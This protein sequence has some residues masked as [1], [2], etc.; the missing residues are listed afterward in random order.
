MDGVKWMAARLVRLVA[1]LVMATVAIATG[2]VS[3]SHI[4]AL[5]LALHGSV[6]AGHLMPIGVDG[7]IVMGSVLLLTATGTTARWGWLGIG[8]GLA[9][10]LFANWE[11][12]IGGGYLAASWATV[13]ALSFAVA[14]F[15]F[16]RW[17]KSQVAGAAGVAASNTAAD[18]GDGGEDEP[19]P[20]PHSLPSTADEAVMTTFLHGRD[21]LGDVPSQRAL[22]IAFGV[23]RLKVAD[24]VKAATGEAPEPAPEPSLN[25]VGASG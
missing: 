10:S 6:L 1:G 12:G 19:G 13:V 4:D 20:C 5:T 7:Q 16:E 18:D 11:S 22:S 9:E 23:N 25:G 21:C 15:S 17:L 2:T 14:S 8:L 3:Y 24:L